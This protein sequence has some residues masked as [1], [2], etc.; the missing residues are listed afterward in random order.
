MTDNTHSLEKEQQVV[1]QKTRGDRRFDW[2]T[3]GMLNGVGTFLLTLPVAYWAEHGKGKPVFDKASHWL[4]GKM[5]EKSVRSLLTSLTLGLGGTIM[6]VP[7]RFMEGMRTEIVSW[8]NRNEPVSG[9]SDPNVPQP[10]PQTWGS[11]LKGRAVSWGVVFG[12]LKGMQFTGLLDGL[13]KF[14]SGFASFVCDKLKL[15]KGTVEAPSKAFKYGELAALDIFATAA[16]ASLT[17]VVSRFFAKH[18]SPEVQ[19]KLAARKQESA[20]ILLRDDAVDAVQPVYA[21]PQSTIIGEKQ[22]V[23]EVAAAG[24]QVG[25]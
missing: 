18:R 7:V 15:A 3:Y 16:A 4:S 14:K 5:S 25:I 10:Q 20:P 23:G 22:R 6:I 1:P 8:F 21:N 17:Y 2:L 9:K 13:D 19:A 12:A 11:L 24:A